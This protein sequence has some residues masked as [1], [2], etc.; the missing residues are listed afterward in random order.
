VAQAVLAIN[1]IGTLTKEE[2]DDLLTLTLQNNQQANKFV[3]IVNKVSSVCNY[4]SHVTKDGS[5]NKSDLIRDHSEQYMKSVFIESH[6]FLSNDQPS[7]D[8][9]KNYADNIYKAE[10]TFRNNATGVERGIM[11]L[12]MKF[13]TNF[14]THVTGTALIINSV[15]KA[16]TGN[17]FLFQHNRSTN[18]VRDTRKDIL[19]TLAKSSEDEP[20]TAQEEALTLTPSVPATM[21]QN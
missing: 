18:A 14:I 16:Q 11:R 20:K 1:H 4:L 10:C 7:I 6:E 21:R 8:D 13:L 15:N 19:E 2:K 9:K 3:K 5:S 17:W 12:V